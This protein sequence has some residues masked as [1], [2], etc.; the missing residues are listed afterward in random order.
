ML[1][2]YRSVQSAH[3]I[4]FYSLFCFFLNTGMERRNVTTMTTTSTKNRLN[5]FFIFSLHTDKLMEFNLDGH[6][7]FYLFL[8]LSFE[9]SSFECVGY[10]NIFCSANGKLLHKYNAH[11]E[12]RFLFLLSLFFIVDE[13]RVFSGVR[14]TNSKQY[15]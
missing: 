12:F 1:K 5:L 4:Q 8:F 10:L 3:I 15:K 7:L 6:R 2:K 13:K 11:L 14:K 9:S